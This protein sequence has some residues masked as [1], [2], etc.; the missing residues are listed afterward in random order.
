[1]SS[2]SLLFLLSSVLMGCALMFV[3]DEARFLSS[4][5]WFA[6]LEHSL[7]LLG[8]LCVGFVLLRLGLMFVMKL[9]LVLC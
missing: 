4:R 5:F 8:A 3:G 6:L 2:L 9:N 1:M 7:Q